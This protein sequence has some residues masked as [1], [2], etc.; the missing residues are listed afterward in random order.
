MVNRVLRDAALPEH[1]EPEELPTVR[2]R[3]LCVGFPYSFIHYLRRAHAHCRSDPSA[4]VEPVAS[5][6]DPSEDERVEELVYDLS[7]HLICHSD[8]EGFYVPVRFGEVLTDRELAGQC[9]GSSPVLLQELKVCAPALGIHLDATGTLCD[10][11]A[12]RVNDQASKNGAIF[13]E[14]TAWI[15]LW[16]A[17]R[18]SVAHGASIE[19]C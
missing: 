16:E 17:A 7:S 19:F 1:L 6:E 15:A 2:S 9:L 12:E 4:P 3:A 11:E 13:R 8:A 5:G 14:L 10:A 18:L